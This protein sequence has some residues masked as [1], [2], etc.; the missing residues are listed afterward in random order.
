MNNSY[1]LIEAIPAILAILFII[2]IGSISSRNERIVKKR[3][4][5]QNEQKKVD[6]QRLLD[7]EL[8]YAER[9]KSVLPDI[10]SSIKLLLS[11]YGWNE[12][13]ATIYIYKNELQLLRDIDYQSPSTR[14]ELPNLSVYG[15]N[16]GRIIKNIKQSTSN[17]SETYR[18]ILD[19]GFDTLSK[20]PTVETL[21]NLINYGYATVD[22]PFT[23]RSRTFVCATTIEGQALIE[24]DDTYKRILSENMYTYRAPSSNKARATVAKT[25]YACIS[26]LAQTIEQK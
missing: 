8:I 1:E 6:N 21:K 11:K 20:E 9:A 5:E 12:I 22:Q 13:L 25:I 24:L 19:Y 18:D 4:E 16:E 15:E 17:N 23:E 3:E 7:E 14:I 26:I 10:D 2:I